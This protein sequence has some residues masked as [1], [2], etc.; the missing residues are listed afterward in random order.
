M[1]FLPKHSI[2]HAVC[3]RPRPGCKTNAKDGQGTPQGPCKPWQVY[4]GMARPTCLARRLSWWLDSCGPIFEDD[5][6]A[7]CGPWKGDTGHGSSADPVGASPAGGKASG[8]ARAV[9]ASGGRTKPEI[10][11]CSD[12]NG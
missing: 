10:P 7:A 12:R 9:P 11:A 5:P 4:D 6:G 2:W 1:A 8:S 3:M